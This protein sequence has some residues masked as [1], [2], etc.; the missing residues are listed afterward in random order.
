MAMSSAAKLMTKEIA[1]IEPVDR[2]IIFSMIGME[3][4]YTK[5]EKRGFSCIQTHEKPLDY[6]KFLLLSSN[7]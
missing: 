2:W 5:T 1:K 3:T 4:N 7:I 6:L